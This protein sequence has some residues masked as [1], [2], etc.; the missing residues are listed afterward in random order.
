MCA[1]SVRG[2]V[3]F[4]D[5][6]MPTLNSFLKLGVKG[7]EVCFSQSDILDRGYNIFFVIKASSLKMR[8]NAI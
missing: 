6:L 8:I 2:T 7:L 5:N 4:V 3:A 1:R